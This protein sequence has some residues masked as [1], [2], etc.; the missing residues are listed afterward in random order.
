MPDRRTKPALSLSGGADLKISARAL[1]VIC[2]LVLLGILMAGLWPFH[3]P[4]NEVTWAGHGN[5][6]RFGKYGTVVSAGLFR[7]DSLHRSDSCSVEIWLEP[8]RVQAMGTILA[9]Y[10]RT[11][12][13]VP[14]MIRQSLGDLELQHT[15]Q[16][17][18]AKRTR[19]YINDVFG[20]SKPVFLTVSS[21]T[22]GTSI[23]TDG[24][25]VKKTSSFI[26]SDVD[27]T[28]QLILGNT[29]TTTDNWGGQVN[30]LAVY[31]RELSAREVVEHFADWTAGMQAELAKTDGVTAFYL[32]NENK[33]RVA[34]NQLSSATDLVI[35][36]RFF[37]LNEQFL[38][39]PWDEYRSDWAFW[40]DVAVNIV[41]F[42]PLGFFFSA[43][44]SSIRN[45]KRVVELTIALGFVVSLTIEGLQA[46]L[47]T[48]NS[49][50]TDLITN[51]LG[52][53]VGLLLYG[54]ASCS[55]LSRN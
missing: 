50:M 12:D 1:L 7:T 26:L 46:F 43:Y 53:G 31:N 32:L 28:G 20:A 51:T 49:G 54:Y 29:P 41:G 48:R 24:V 25:L 8:R 14:F 39:R 35:P 23:Y 5:G 55:Q 15:T 38:E 9:F 11:D 33:G 2:A 18:F 36:E 3:S 13:I 47:P 37:I 22:T 17:Y 19:I 4:K 30:S 42:I 34:H 40:K 45:T 44:L 6:L 10:R 16:R 27:L 52:T 21:D